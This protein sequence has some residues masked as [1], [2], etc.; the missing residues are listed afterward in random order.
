LDSPLL[1]AP[2][3]VVVMGNIE[4]FFVVDLLLVSIGIAKPNSNKYAHH[5]E[6][7]GGESENWT[8]HNGGVPATG[9]SMP[10]MEQS[11]GSS[12]GKT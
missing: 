7:Y 4:T 5:G 3:L 12:P 2:S 6:S 9:Y 8:I 10:S 1:D 11:S